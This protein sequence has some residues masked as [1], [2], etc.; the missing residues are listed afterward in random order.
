MRQ[1]FGDFLFLLH[2]MSRGEAPVL[3]LADE[4][5]KALVVCSSIVDWVVG[6][7]WLVVSLAA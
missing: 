6:I 2:T 1:H 7:E 4:F 3:V 5:G